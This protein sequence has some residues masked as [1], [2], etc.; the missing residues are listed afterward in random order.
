MNS[1]PVEVKRHILGYCNIADI[2][3]LAQTS[4]AL[5]SI[6]CDYIQHR[7]HLLTMPFFDN[8]GTL[9][10]LLRSC[11]AVVSGS[12]VLHLM[13]PANETPWV[14]TDLDI[15]VS[16]CQLTYLSVLLEREGYV[17]MHQC[18][19]EA[20]P[21]G[22]SSICSVVSFSNMHRSIDVIVS[23]TVAAVSPI[24]EFHST[25]VMN[26]ITADN[27]FCAYPMLTLE[28]MSMVNAGPL[29]FE[30]F[31]FRTMC[32]LEKSMPRSIIDCHG[33]WINISNMRRV[34]LVP[35]EVFESL[36]F[37]DLIWVLG[38][39]VCGSLYPF[40]RA[41]CFLIEDDSHELLGRQFLGSEELT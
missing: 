40:V 3:R 29:Y 32:A 28:L 2:T 38:G 22:S 19:V 23:S 25:A 17:V 31:G 10:G 13:L 16:S 11:D 8:V 21:Y 12:C 15:Y 34:S 4:T 36:G 39:Y 41:Q 18:S 5:N 20:G 35:A 24:F 6:A 9:M 14:S 27:I 7:L 37:I 30:A 26:F 33:L 1:L